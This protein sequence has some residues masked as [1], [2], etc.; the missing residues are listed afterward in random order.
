MK[1]ARLKK[2]LSYFKAKEQKLGKQL[3]K[4]ILVMKENQVHSKVGRQ[5]SRENLIEIIEE[6]E[7][8]PSQSPKIRGS[9]SI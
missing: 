8:Q 2:E 3:N 6:E 5:K 7:L 1:S 9:I 4:N